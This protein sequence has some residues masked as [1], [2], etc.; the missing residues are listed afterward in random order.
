[1]A[2]RFIVTMT[3]FFRHSYEYSGKVR[4]NICL[5]ECHKHLDQVNEKQTK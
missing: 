2:M 3:F 4:K 1:M 5:Y